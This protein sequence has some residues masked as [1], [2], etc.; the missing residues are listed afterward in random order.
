MTFR[1]RKQTRLESAILPLKKGKTPLRELGKLTQGDRIQVREFLFEVERVE[2]QSVI[3][4]RIYEIFLDRLLVEKKNGERDLVHKSLQE[5]S[6]SRYRIF[7]QW[8]QATDIYGLGM[9]TL[10]L[11]FIRGLFRMKKRSTSPVAK[12]SANLSSSSSIYDRG[13]REAIFGELA[14]LLRNRSF[15]ENL[16]SHLATMELANFSSLQK[17]LKEPKNPKIEVAKEI[18]E[19]IRSTDTNFEFIWHGLNQD[20]GLFSQLSRSPLPPETHVRPF[21]VETRDGLRIIRTTL[22]IE[23]IGCAQHSLE[24]RGVAVTCLVQACLR[25][26]WWHLSS[27][28]IYG[29]RPDWADL[30]M[31]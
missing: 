26:Y 5:A 12:S 18:S 22:L 24:M 10:Y 23:L 9:I 25:D 2:E 17:E 15:L 4:S 29:V 30:P 1:W 31:I 21:S 11:F 14:I 3:V 6:I 20:H 28:T 19:W 13:N 16:L 7:Q 27:I 8:S